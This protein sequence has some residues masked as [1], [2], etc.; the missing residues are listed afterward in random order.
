MR[1]YIVAASLMVAFV[2]TMVAYVIL[3]LDNVE[4]GP[5]DELL[6]ILGGAIAGATV[7]AAR[8]R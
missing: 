5:L 2:L 7:P 3:R 8:V 1:D 4:G 6:L